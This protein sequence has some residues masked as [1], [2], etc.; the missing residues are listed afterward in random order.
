MKHQ[1]SNFG[2][3]K[4]CVSNPHNWAC[5]GLIEISKIQ[6]PP[7]P[8]GHSYQIYNDQ[9]QEL[10]SQILL[11]KND[12]FTIKF[13]AENVSSNSSQNFYLKPRD[14]TGEFSPP[15]EGLMDGNDYYL[16]NDLFRIVIEEDGSYTLMHKIEPLESE[17]QEP[18]LMIMGEEL[19]TGSIWAD[20]EFLKYFQLGSLR[21]DG[22]TQKWIQTTPKLMEASDFFG[23]LEV[24]QKIVPSELITSQIQTNI[25]IHK[26]INGLIRFETKFPT[27]SVANN[28][29]IEVLFPI[30]FNSYEFIEEPNYA[31]ILDQTHTYGLGFFG[32]HVKIHHSKQTP[33]GTAEVSIHLSHESQIPADYSF[34]IHYA[35]VPI[36]NL[37]KESLAQVKEIVSRYFQEFSN[38]LKVEYSLID[39]FK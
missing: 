23:R 24:L 39:D 22:E 8:I 34:H 25:C 37:Q 35:I 19:G 21:I 1:E 4:I 26:G 2:F 9:N 13:L 10:T 3:I 31:L 38:P 30:P 7:H 6:L 5:S 16:E 11:E 20:D 27:R 33:T 12:T 36:M 28:P 32:K 15:E 17:H 14:P 29:K 18:K